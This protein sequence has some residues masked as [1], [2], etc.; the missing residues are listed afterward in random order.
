MKTV[1]ATKNLSPG[2]VQRRNPSTLPTAPTPLDQ[3]GHTI[4][5]SC[6][7][8]RVLTNLT[9]RIPCVRQSPLH[10]LVLIR[11]HTQERTR[12]HAAD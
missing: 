8:G 7:K 10:F 9:K 11:K 4:S 2:L 5:F 3:P 12:R 1:N 6:E